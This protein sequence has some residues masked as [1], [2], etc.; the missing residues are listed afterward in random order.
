MYAY[1]IMPH[2]NIRIVNGKLMKPK[3]VILKEPANESKPKK[4]VTVIETKIVNDR[5]DEAQIIGEGFNATSFIVNRPAKAVSK[6]MS[7]M[8]PKKLDKNDI[9]T[10]LGLL[11]FG[12][13][14]RDTKSKNIKLII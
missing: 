6:S 13:S 7:I 11:N 9:V 3:R 2:T 1:D 4:S 10:G 5:G 8:N 12:S 14:L